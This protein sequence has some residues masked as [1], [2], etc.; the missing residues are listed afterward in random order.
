MIETDVRPAHP[1]RPD[2]VVAA[3]LPAVPAGP[4]RGR[5]FDLVERLL[6][7]AI[8]LDEFVMGVRETAL[9]P[10]DAARIAAACAALPFPGARVTPGLEAGERSAAAGRSG[11]RRVAGDRTDDR[12]T[13]G[14]PGAGGTLRVGLWTAPEGLDPALATTRT[15]RLLT[16]QLYST[17]TSIDADGRPY[18]DLAEWIEISDDLCTYTFGLRPGQTFHDG[19]PVTAEDVAFS[20]E[21]IADPAIDYHFEPWTV[22]MAGADVVRPGVVRLRLNQ[23]TGP[24]LT[25]L[26]FCGSG[27]VPRGAV[28]GGR[29]LDREPIGSGPFRL[30]GGRI[31]AEALG[32]TVRLVRHGRQNLDAI[33]FVT[34]ADDAERAAALLD[35]RVHLDALL[36]PRAWGAATA[37]SDV[38]AS[39]VPDGRWHWLMVNC[40]DPLLSDVRVRRAVATA[41]DRRALL[42]EGFEGLG[43][44]LTGGVIAPWSWAHAGDLAGFSD[45]GDAAG[46]RALLDEAGVAPGT[47]LEIA[48]MANMPIAERQGELIAAQ[49]RAAGLAASVRIMDSATWA[50]AV[51]RDG[52]FQLATS[53]WGSPI[54]DPDDFVYMGYRSGARFDTGIC[55][56]PVLDELMDA[57]RAS[58]VQADRAA[59]Y[60]RLQALALEELP[61]IPTIQ[62]PI[63]R[64]WSTRLRGFVPMRN[65]QLKTLR[66]AW[67]VDDGGP[68]ANGR[69]NRQTNGRT[70]V[71][72]T[73]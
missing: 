64:G 42:D 22:T 27:I 63:L 24:M 49:L 51:R 53:Y 59:A 16:E 26:A 52:S 31:E 25:W 57:G 33:E 56:S 47:K 11:D 28:V 43:L 41:I 36:S 67:L 4:E 46:A 54:N 1:P 58:I 40:R 34:I 7:Q 55:G 6:A 19:S 18:P 72:S 48:S 71:S 9:T 70:N 62:P 32:G 65:A 2:V 17:L 13:E 35:G 12:R 50:V 61:L 21:R 8:S 69:T 66:D 60:R 37:S 20:L 68:A 15:S 73:D 29:S 5:L 39:S 3:V 10:A 14:R 38:V 23:P 44:T 30:A 45:R